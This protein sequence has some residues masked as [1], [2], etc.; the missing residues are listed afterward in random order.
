MKIFALFIT[1]S[2]SVFLAG[3]GIS[4]PHLTEFYDW[5]DSLKSR[6]MQLEIKR[7][8]YCELR[9][10]G[11]E[12]RERNLR[13]KHRGMDVTTVEDIALPP[14]WGA[15][16]ELS[17]TVNEKSTLSPNVSL[18]NPLPN[19]QSFTFGFGGQLSSE[20]NRIDKF[21]YYYS[22]KQLIDDDNGR[23]TCYDPRSLGHDSASSPFLVKSNLGIRDWLIDAVIINSQLRSSRSE[24]TGIGHPLG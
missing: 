24:D 21:D 16:I 11:H 2:Q 15:Q 19:D 14:T 13:R 22:M 1:V 12:A 4:V 18:I 20:A 3:C 23:N 6:Y 9:K 10:A 17:F 8:I 5:D 7:A